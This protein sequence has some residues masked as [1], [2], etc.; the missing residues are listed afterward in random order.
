[1]R[2]IIRLFLL[3][4]GASFAAAGL[5]HRGVLVNGYQH[6]QATLAESV[7]AAVLLVGLALTWAWPARTRLIGPVTQAFALLG[8]L[9]GAFT[10]AV[11]IGPRTAPDITYHV[12]I[13]IVLA[14]GL[15][16]AMRAP[17]DGAMQR[18]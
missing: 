1:M 14:W 2:R 13:L 17:A 18:A 10:I 9:V 12:A 11:G 16:V 3:V 8:T 5:V 6:R 4:E 7:I 15:V